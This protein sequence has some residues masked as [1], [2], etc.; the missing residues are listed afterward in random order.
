MNEIISDMR[1]L[2]RENPSYFPTA[3]QF[4]DKMWES[5]F[6]QTYGEEGERFES[7]EDIFTVNGNP[8]GH[9]VFNLICSKRDLS[10]WTIGM[11]PHRHWKVSEV[12]KYFGIKGNRDELFRQITLIHDVIVNGHR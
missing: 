4:T 12:K 5:P 10:L 11:K 1:E 8:T 7:G 9:A 2:V 3:S 6:M